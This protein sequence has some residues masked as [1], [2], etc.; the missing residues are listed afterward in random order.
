MKEALIA[1]KPNIYFTTPHF[2]GYPAV[3]VRLDK[4]GVKDLKDLI[5]EAWFARAPKKVVD[6]FLKTG[7]EKKSSSKRNTRRRR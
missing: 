1:S 6:A 3:L 7:D 5:L 4:I 2:D